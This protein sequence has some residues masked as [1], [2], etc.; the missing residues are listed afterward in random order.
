MK[1]VILMCDGLGNRWIN[2][3]I[4]YKHLIPF[5]GVPLISRT[6]N[7][8][9]DQYCDIILVAPEE[10]K[11]HIEIPENVLC[12][13]LGYRDEEPRTLLDGILRTK[14]FWSYDTSV[15][16]GDV[17]FSHRSINSLFDTYYPEHIL[18][19]LGANMV[20]RKQA[21][22][23]FALSFT[24]NKTTFLNLKSLKNTSGKLWDYFKVYKP[25]LLLPNDYTDDFDSPQAYEQFYDFMLEAVRRDDE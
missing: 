5:D 24:D 9:Q 11:Y 25:T 6:I 23:L 14:S 16:L 4:P 18:G 7:Q 15:L 20:T 3:Y 1:T 13:S 22:E 19:R 17:V 10:F 8:L 12:T 21:G 2:K